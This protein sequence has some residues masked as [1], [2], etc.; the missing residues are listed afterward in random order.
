MGREYSPIHSIQVQKSFF[1]HQSISRQ[2]F[3]SVFDA[4][5]SSSMFHENPGGLSKYDIEEKLQQ[6]GTNFIRIDVPPVYRLIAKEVNG[7]KQIHLKIM[8][9]QSTELLFSVIQPILPG[10]TVYCDCLDGTGILRLFYSS[11]TLYHGRS[12]FGCLRNSKGTE[13][14]PSM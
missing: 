13:V 10:P 12:R 11:D 14:K 2:M 9:G 4:D 5:M 7:F 1:T 3:S 6:Y 8:C